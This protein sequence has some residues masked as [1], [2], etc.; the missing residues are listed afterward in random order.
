MKSNVKLFKDHLYL[1]YRVVRAMLRGLKVPRSSKTGVMQ[2]ED[3]EP[4]YSVRNVTYFE[5]GYL[6]TSLKPLS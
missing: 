1:G 2:T 4:N 6:N 3:F 5:Q